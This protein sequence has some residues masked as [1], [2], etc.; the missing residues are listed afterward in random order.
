MGLESRH[1]DKEAI[2]AQSRSSHSHRERIL[3]ARGAI[4]R[5]EH[6]VVVLPE[7]LDDDATL[8]AVCARHEHVAIALRK[9]NAADDAAN[10]RASFA[11][12]AGNRSGSSASASSIGVADH[13]ARFV[14]ADRAFDRSRAAIDDAWTDH[15]VTGTDGT[16]GTLVDAAARTDD[17][18]ARTDHA[19]SRADD[20]VA[21]TDDSVHAARKYDKS[22]C[23]RR[24][25]TVPAW[26]TARHDLPLTRVP[27]QV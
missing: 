27:I 18:L 25:L 17:D 1:L 26:N 20:T 16:S 22:A 12:S 4:N 9:W 7:S 24:H 3:H 19:I 13:S 15:T 14:N 11:R 21:W 6:P 2:R 23:H 10:D 5:T 8:R